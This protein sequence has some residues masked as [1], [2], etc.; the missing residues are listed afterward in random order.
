MSHGELPRVPDEG[1]DHVAL[2][3]GLVDQILSSLPSGSHH[4]DL[5]P[6]TLGAKSRLQL[7]QNTTL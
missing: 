6:L 1:C 2:Q 5:H 4:S 3:Q 7:K